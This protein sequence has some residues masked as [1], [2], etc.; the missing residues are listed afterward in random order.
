[1][2][3]ETPIIWSP[4]IGV[5][6]K[7]FSLLIYSSLLAYQEE[8]Y[9]STDTV[10]I[11]LSGITGISLNYS[12]NL[13]SGD[14]IISY[15]DF[16][17]LRTEGFLDPNY[18]AIITSASL[19]YFCTNIFYKRYIILSSAGAI[20]VFIS[21]LST[22][23]RTGLFSFLSGFAITILLSINSMFSKKKAFII[24][25]LIIMLSIFSSIIILN[26]L[27]SP[28]K[29]RFTKIKEGYSE[30]RELCYI[31]AINFIKKEPLTGNGKEYY[32]NENSIISAGAHNTFLNMFAEGGILFFL[33]FVLMIFYLFKF[34]VGIWTHPEKEIFMASLII[35][36]I[37]S[38]GLTIAI[39]DFVFATFITIFSIALNKFS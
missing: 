29:Q 5:Y 30:A 34:I 10:F 15:N 17:G 4:V 16:M 26:K 23:S 33:V 20:I 37:A 14:K 27:P 12:F 11:L 19:I 28:I 39:G 7:L 36:C 6:I 25:G 22:G 35:F 3:S 32:L 21:L 31:N 9:D 8:G 18:I 24:A 2:I 1:L 13:F 38:L